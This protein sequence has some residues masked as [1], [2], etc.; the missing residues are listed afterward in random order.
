M[1]KN[2]IRQRRI[3]LGLKKGFTLIEMLM[4]V[5]IMI[6]VGSVLVVFIPQVTRQ[7]A[8]MQAKSEV[9]DNAT[10]IMATMEKEIK[11]S[12]SVYIPTTVFDTS[13]GQL[14]LETR[15]N[16]ISTEEST[17][18][19]FYVDDD[20]LY[21]KR[22]EQSAQLLLSDKIKIDSLIFT[23]LNAGGD[24]PVI[25]IALTASYDSSSSEVSAQSQVTLTSTVSAR[26][27]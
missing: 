16:T 12:V 26:E 3:S 15:F 20:R 17:F 23:N 8:Y 14:S 25:R 1:F 24:Y 7:N 9:L 2:N 4:Y 13:P 10:S 22:E 18:V 21:I 6:V 11:H 27:Y 5:A 19:D